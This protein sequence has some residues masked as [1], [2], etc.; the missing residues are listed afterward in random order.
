MGSSALLSTQTWLRTTHKPPRTR[1]SPTS[2]TSS[3]TRKRS[4]SAVTAV[5]SAALPRPRTPVPPT[6]RPGGPRSLRSSS[7]TSSPT[8][9]LTPSL[10]ASTWTGYSSPTS[11][12]TRHSSSVA[13]IPC[14][15]SHQPVHVVSMPRGDDPVPEGEDCQGRQGSQDRWQARC[16]LRLS[17]FCLETGP[18]INH[19][20]CNYAG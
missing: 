19:E 9:R 18:W 20:P 10:R 13:H 2:S 1:P 5:V 17:N 4:L 15:R 6:V 14:S 3:S 12:S 7:S 8:L 16:H 11:R